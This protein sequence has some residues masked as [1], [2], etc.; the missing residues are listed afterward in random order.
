[1]HEKLEYMHWNPVKRELVRK[2]EDWPW[3]SAR[4]YKGDRS[5]VVEIAPMRPKRPE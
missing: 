3:S 4:W 1:L 5:S 2:P